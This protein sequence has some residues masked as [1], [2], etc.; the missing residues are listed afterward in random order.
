VRTESSIERS[1]QACEEIASR[2]YEN[3]PVASFFLPREKRKHVAAIYAFARTADDIADEQGLPSETRLA[4]LDELQERL[5]QCS[6]GTARGP[7][8]IALGETIRRHQVPVEYFEN[9][10]KAFR[11][12]VEKHRYATWQELLQYCSYSANP[13]GRLVLHL[14]RYR[15]ED[16]FQASDATCTALQLTNFWQDLSIDLRRGR[17]YIPLEDLERFHCTES[18]I[19]AGRMNDRLRSLLCFQVERTIEMFE[20]GRG[21]WATVGKNLRLQLKVTWLSGMRV[22]KKIRESE[23]DVF[24]NRPMISLLD[25]GIIVL[26]ALRVGEN[27]PVNS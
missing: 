5:Q 26:H 25:K 12:D 21:V 3:F 24:R 20:K 10:L 13:I 16:Q 11:M 15:T 23:Y 6:N 22:L 2:H 1:F 9:L 8:F 27:A 14:F 7:L 19:L 17:L 4:K 18:D